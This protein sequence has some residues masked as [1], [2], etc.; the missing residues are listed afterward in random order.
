M[1]FLR[2][3][4]EQQEGL[5]LPVKQALDEIDMAA[6][7]TAAHRLKGAARTIGAVGLSL[8]C[9][10]IEV[11]ATAGDNAQFRDMRQAFFREAERLTHYLSKVN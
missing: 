10:R 9:E 2:S 3:F 6:I 7:K 4:R 1:Q 11:T 5:F 8:A